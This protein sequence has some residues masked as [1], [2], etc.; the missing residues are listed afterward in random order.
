MGG[1][2]RRQ[3]CGRCGLQLKVPSDSESFRCSSCQSITQVSPS[4]PIRGA[5]NKLASRFS[6]A[7]PVKAGPT[8]A[9]APISVGGPT[10][11]HQQPPVTVHYGGGYGYSP[12][13]AS[14]DHHN[15]GR[16][17]R[18]K[19][20]LCGVSYKDKSY[21]IKGSINDVNCMRYFLIHKFG[22]PAESILTLTEEEINPKRIPTKENI[23]RGMKWLVEGCKAGDSLM[24]YFS[25]HGT[26]QRDYDMDELD[27]FDE[28][29]CP[30]DFEMEG[31]IIDDEINSTIVAPL[32]PGTVLH[33]VIDS[34]HS[35]TVL[36]LP[37]ACRVN[38]EGQYAWEDHRR[39]GYSGKK[40]TSG[41]LAI[42][43]SAC[44]DHQTS[45]DTNVMAGNVSTGA[46][47]YSLIQ[48]V[49]NEPG[50]SYGRLLNAMRVAIRA[51]RTQGLRLSGPIASLVNVALFSTES[52]QEPQL[53]CSQQFDVFS[54]KFA[55]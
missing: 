23:R 49:Q 5:I 16:G 45:A 3:R 20:L 15:Q 32:P 1:S 27:G 30:L 37:F 41:G 18:K 52:T 33:A 13:P 44:N 14:A 55:L 47:T 22:Y 8:S 36:D 31:M 46:L 25:G 43:I 42:C 6:T 50:I 39:S 38:R 40:D 28:T 21:R 19:A 17:G 54:R 4:S 29:L 7:P 26:Q 48:A 24:F 34:C 53:T 51:A 2:S 10:A 12:T 11:H 9:A 35:G